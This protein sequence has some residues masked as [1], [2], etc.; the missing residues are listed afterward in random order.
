MI[1]NKPFEAS[2]LFTSNAEVNPLHCTAQKVLYLP[3][4]WEQKNQNFEGQWINFRCCHPTILLST[5]VSTQKGPVLTKVCHDYRSN[6]FEI[7]QV[8][9]LI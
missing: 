3:C 2:T 9:V 7:F 1:N 4:Y 5:T 8:D 6:A